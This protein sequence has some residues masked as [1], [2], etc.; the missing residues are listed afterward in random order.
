[1]K[2]GNVLAAKISVEIGIGQRDEQSIGFW[3]CVDV[4]IAARYF[5]EVDPHFIGLKIGIVIRRARRLVFFGF[6]VVSG[7]LLLWAVGGGSRQDFLAEIFHRAFR[8]RQLD[9]DV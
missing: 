3:R 7:W 1:M 4:V 8:P 2:K 6:A 5:V 9:G